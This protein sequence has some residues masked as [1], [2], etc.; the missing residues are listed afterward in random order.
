MEKTGYSSGA[1]EPALSFSNRSA[2]GFPVFSR[3]P[4]LVQSLLGAAAAR[5][6]CA[7]RPHSSSRNFD[8]TQIRRRRIAFSSAA[9]VTIQHFTCRAA[10]SRRR[11]E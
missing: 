9:D 2:A 8:T 3:C 7:T 10:R 4:Q 1:S 5:L 6:P 11:S